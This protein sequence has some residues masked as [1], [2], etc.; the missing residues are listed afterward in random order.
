MTT[1][2]AGGKYTSA[3]GH[4]VHLDIAYPTS[5]SRWKIFFK[6]LFV[7]P[8]VIVLWFVAIAFSVITFFA[9]WAVLFTGRYPRGFFDFAESFLRWQVN[10][11][12]YTYLLTDEYPPF[13]GAA[14]R[15]QSVQFSVD[16]PDRMNQILVLFKWLTVIPALIVYFF[17]TIAAAVVEFIAFWAIL[18]TGNMPR[19]LFDYLVGTIRWG[20]RINAYYYMLTDAYPPFRLGD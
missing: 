16:Y 2:A 1:I 3:S 18:F 14:G 8:N 5:L 12:A 17:V 10:L 13:S 20:Q 9:W 15:S 4:P 11:T 7:I 6:G 19:G